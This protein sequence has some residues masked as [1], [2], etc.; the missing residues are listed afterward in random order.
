MVAVSLC[1]RLWVD[2]LLQIKWQHELPSFLVV[3]V[4]ADT[5][6]EKQYFDLLLG[7][8]GPD[9]FLINISFPT[10]VLSVE[11]CSAR[12]FNILEH[13][14]PGSILK[15]F[16]L[17]VPFSDPSVLQKAS[18]YWGGAQS[19]L[20]ANPYFSIHRVKWG[21]L[22][23][24]S[25]WPLACW[26]CQSSFNFLTWLILKRKWPTLVSGVISP[27]SRPGAWAF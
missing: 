22:F 16:T 6:P 18:F 23:S 3:T 19:H 12:G 15:F 13:T 7:S 2:W 9:V 21:W 1:Y 4:L 24:L 26:S 17:Q 11:E 5:V 8:F 27:F 20:P 14:F 10:G 25:T